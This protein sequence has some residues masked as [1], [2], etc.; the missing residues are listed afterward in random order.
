M[1]QL[2]VPTSFLAG[3]L[4]GVARDA[5]PDAAEPAAAPPEAVV[6]SPRPPAE[7]D[8]TLRVLHQRWVTV[9]DGCLETELECGDGEPVDTLRTAWAR[10]LEHSGDIKTLLDAYVGDPV[11]DQL[12]ERHLLRLARAAGML[13][14]GHTPREGLEEIERVLATVAPAHT[15][16]LGWFAR[17]WRKAEEDRLIREARGGW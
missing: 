1:P 8:Q 17:Q 5:G 14:P 16:K 10:A 2:P 12:T 6:P 3:A 7:A 4:S 11:H 13:R 15:E 9:V